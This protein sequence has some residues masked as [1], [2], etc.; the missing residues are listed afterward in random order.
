M[1]DI[2]IRE[3]L[4]HLSDEPRRGWLARGI[5]RADCESVAEHSHAVS[6][7][8]TAYAPEQLKAKA[9][10]LAAAHDVA[11]AVTG[12]I[13]PAD[14]VGKEAKLSRERLAYLFLE[15]MDPVAGS[16]LTE[17]WREYQENRT[18]AA[19]LVHDADKL[20][21]L[22]RA[23]AY[24]RRFPKLD[25]S[26]FKHDA[27]QIVGDSMRQEAR[28]VLEKWTSWEQRRQTFIF[29]IGGPGVGK[30][31]QCSKAAATLRAAHVSAGELLR[32]EQARPGSRFRDF[33]TQSFEMS[34]PVPPTLIIDLVREAIQHDPCETIF[35]DGFPL[36]VEQLRYFE[37]ELSIKYGTVLLDAGSETLRRRLQGRA[38]SS[39]RADDEP[40]RIDKRI[41]AFHARPSP[42]MDLLRSREQPFF[43]V[44][45]EA[46]VEDVQAKFVEYA[47]AILRLYSSPH[48][49]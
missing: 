22:D 31:T 11:E 21:R 3:V 38:E 10:E 35:L 19:Q 37:N 40:D 15:S 12:D 36:T 9:T 5:P 32:C 45:G 33:I 48:L 13:I 25:L 28:Q 16:R 29:V 30:G 20:Q 27:T 18:E 14:Q 23:F 17:L 6:L 41:E 44:D 2:N 1:V 43:A 49:T 7:I 47:Q 34:I 26:D 8:C 4:S 42:V 24:A 39:G 46:E